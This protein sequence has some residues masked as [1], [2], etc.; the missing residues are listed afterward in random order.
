MK[1]KKR[2]RATAALP[3]GLTMPDR[4]AYNLDQF[5]AAMGWSRSMTYNLMKS[6]RLTYF[7]NGDKRYVTPEAARNCIA[8]L[9]RETA[10]RLAAERGAGQAAKAS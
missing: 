4:L 8:L 5:T 9:E 6:G 2:K 10:E 7:T 3:P 1:T